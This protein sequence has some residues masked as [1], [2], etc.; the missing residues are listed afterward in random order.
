[1]ATN[2]TVPEALANSAR[3]VSIYFHKFVEL[4]ELIPGG[5]IIIR[6]IKSS[7]KDDPFRTVL[8]L[9]LFIFA[10]RYFTTKRYESKKKG[11]IKL[12]EREINELVE[13]WEPEPLVLPVKD[14]E[15]WKLEKIDII[16]KPG[17]DSHINTTKFPNLI[18][19]A[20]LN[21]LNLSHH[22]KIISEAKRIISQNGVGACG[23]PNFYGNQDIHI[24]LEQSICEFFKV[25]GCVLY[26][27]D[28]ATA[29]SVLPSFLKRGDY[30]L[31]DSKCN[32]SIQKAL[33]LSRATVTYFNHNDTEH[34]ENILTEFQ[35]EVFKYEKSGE[36]SRKFIITEGLFANSGDLPNL[37][38]LI[39]LKKRFKFRLFIDESLSIG[40]LGKSGR[41]L[42]EHYS[43][44]ITDVDI[45]MG[46]LSNAL[47]GTGGF[48]IGDKVMSYHQRIGSLAYCFSASL[49]A[50]VTKVAST[51]LNLIDQE[52]NS[53][54]ESKIVKL[55]Q[56]NIKF[57]YNKFVKDSKL[58]EFI[59]IQSSPESS[60]LQ[61]QLSK[62]IRN[63]FEFDKIK[64]T[65][66]NSEIGIRNKKGQSDKFIEKY[67]EEEQILQKIVDNCKE[68][69]VLITKSTFSLAQEALNII[70]TLKICINK[71]LT[72]DELNKSFEILKK[73]I[74]LELDQ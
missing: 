62:S 72:H 28:F 71:D 17:Y 11:Q 70:P 31:V 46:S 40:V 5:A 27:Q 30:V 26:G 20:S 65:G 63:V 41:G 37:P 44:P 53:Q 33:L 51:T 23:P 68:N 1:M 13:E 19:L 34:L 58:L 32:L 21:F 45:I 35:D 49:P 25:D 16:T 29:Q 18:N 52:K 54:G 67:N 3:Q 50:Y 64:Y 7:H 8:E 43:I 22:P 36:I 12:S 57:I 69:G 39:E 74:L 42:T 73:S 10:I 56:D 9:A 24:N 2:I 59:E 48:C 61:F 38:K 60:I 47:N 14:Q 66:I 4:I 55:L 6:Y 15:R